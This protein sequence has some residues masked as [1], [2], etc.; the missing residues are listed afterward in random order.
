MTL[1]EPS[2]KDASSI[3]NVSDYDDLLHLIREN[4]A[5]HITIYASMKAVQAV[6]KVQ[7]VGPSDDDRSGGEDGGEDDL[8]S[9]VPQYLSVS[10][11]GRLIS[12]DGALRPAVAAKT[13]QSLTKPWLTSWESSSKSMASKVRHRWYIARVSISGRVPIFLLLGV[14]HRNGREQWYDLQYRAYHGVPVF[15]VL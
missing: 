15:T 10:D 6:C 5:P 13:A 9:T 3:D 4:D 14:W 1:H 8:V 2:L 11:E 7:E 12:L